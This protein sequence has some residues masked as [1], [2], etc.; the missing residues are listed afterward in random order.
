MRKLNDI[1]IRDKTKYKITSLYDDIIIYLM[2]FTYMP[3]ILLN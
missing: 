1:F 2:N 3:N